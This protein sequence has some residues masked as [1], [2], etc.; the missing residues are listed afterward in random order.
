[1]MEVLGAPLRLVGGVG[2]HDPPCPAVHPVTAV[3]SEYSLWTRELE[4]DVVP[5]CADLGI[6]FVPLSTLGKGVL[7]GTQSMRYRV[8]AQDW[9]GVTGGRRISWVPH[10]APHPAL[11]SSDRS[12]GCG[13]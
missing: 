2:R 8:G 4:T 13:S 11:C 1:M 9:R 5:T 12:V 10:L 3:Q 6:G 7:T